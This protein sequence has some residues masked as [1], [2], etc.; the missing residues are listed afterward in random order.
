MVIP[1]KFDKLE[2]QHIDLIRDKLYK[3]APNKANDYTLTGLFMWRDYFKAYVAFED[4]AIFIYQLVE[5][6]YLF[7]F[8]IC[9]DVKRGLEKI[10]SFANEKGIAYGFYPLCKEEMLILDEMGLNYTSYYSDDFRDYLY[11]KEDLIAFQGKKYHSQ[12][13]HLNRFLFN[14]P[15]YKYECINEKNIWRIREFFEDYCVTH[16]F[17]D[18][19]EEEEYN[20]IPEL[21]NNMDAYKL[22]GYYL[23]INGSIQGFELGEIVDEM[24]YSHVQKANVEVHGIYAAMVSFMARTLPETVK[25]INREEDMGNIGLRTSKKRYRPCGYVEKYMIYCQI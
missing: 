6:K 8:P 4:S 23:E 14:Y 9:S 2:L 3:Y 15:D 24:Y 21:L 5:D 18:K 13:N 11:Q 10:S 19:T 16:P 22:L 12:R 17:R 7:Y 20:K 25:Y 1:M